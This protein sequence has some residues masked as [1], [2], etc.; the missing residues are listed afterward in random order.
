M[1]P[2]DIFNK[3]MEWKLYPVT[4]DVAVS[5]DYMH[6]AIKVAYQS[7]LLDKETCMQAVEAINEYIKDSG[8]LFIFLSDNDHSATMK[9]QIAI[10]Q[11]W[12]HRPKYD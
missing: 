9:D 5:S 10:Y 2:Q 4:S 7:G 3:I 6:V 11:N 8:T 12:E 1:T